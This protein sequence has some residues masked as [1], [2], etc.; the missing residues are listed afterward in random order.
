MELPEQ[1]DH[2]QARTFLRELQ[3]LLE[4]DRPR[5]VLECSQVRLIDSSGVEM[6]LRCMQEAMKRDGDLKLA[7]VSAASGAILEL[8]RVDRLFEVFDTA[9]E[10]VQSFDAFQSHAVPQRAP[11]QKAT[12]GALEN[13]KAAS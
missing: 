6:L 2:T 1:L 4:T 10:A 13:L 12:Y 7:G 9:K 8:M 5:L 3:V 11:H